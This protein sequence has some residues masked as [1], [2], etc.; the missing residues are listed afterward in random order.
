MGRLLLLSV[1]YSI[2]IWNCGST[3]K[4]KKSS[5][6]DQAAWVKEGISI[7][8][9][10]ADWSV[11]GF[12]KNKASKISY[13][14]A[15]DSNLMYLSIYSED[16][17]TQLK[18]TRSGLQVNLNN[19]PEKYEKYKILFQ[20]D[21]PQRSATSREQVPRSFDPQNPNAGLKQRVLNAKKYFTLTGFGD[22]N[23]KYELGAPN[24][25]GIKASIT[26]TD[27]GYLLYEMSIPLKTIEAEIGIGEL[28]CGISVNGLTLPSS[29]GGMSGPVSGGGGSPM[30]GMRPP[31]GGGGGM[32]PGGS[33]GSP[34]GGQ[35]DFQDLA[36][37]YKF[38][39]T[40]SLAHPGK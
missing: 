6:E 38:W 7:D 12:E 32:P 2:L 9:N 26:L 10:M 5:G 31:P 1:F 23:G 29:G 30:G 35:A 14:F 19:G 16:A 34:D 37:S 15:N 33:M 25:P 4:Q 8:G 24:E 27:M 39:K 11:V 22:A 28:T 17:G 21:Q 40:F 3:K 13:A 20:F 36:K 18:M